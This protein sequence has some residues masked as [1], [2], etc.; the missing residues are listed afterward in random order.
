MVAV[1][2]VRLCLATVRLGC[3]CRCAWVGVVWVW[4]HTRVGRY[5]S[6]MLWVGGG[7][8]HGVCRCASPGVCVCARA[9][10]REP[11]KREEVWCPRPHV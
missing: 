6:E 3:V 7:C 2:A 10:A 9:A 11:P 5:S 4:P 1:G 8:P